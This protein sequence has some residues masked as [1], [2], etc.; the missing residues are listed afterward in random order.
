MI[1]TGELRDVAGTPFDFTK[2]KS[3]G[4]DINAENEQLKFGSGWDH[5]WVLDRDKAA[6]DE[7][8]LAARVYEPDTG[9]IMEVLTTEPG[10][11]FYCGNFLSG[12]IIGKAGKPYGKRGG[13]CLETQH[14]PD[15][16]NKPEF[17]T[18]ILKPGEEY[19]TSTSFRFSAK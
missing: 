13:F 10:V 9:R 4:K 3:I 12:N 19:R 6:A 16:P 2:S 7:R 15:S 17:P 18:C 5:N 1:P 11:Q 8:T 14:Y